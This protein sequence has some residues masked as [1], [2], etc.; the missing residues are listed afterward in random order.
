V[1][2]PESIHSP[3]TW[4]RWFSARARFTTGVPLLVRPSSTG[5]VRRPLDVPDRVTRWL[6]GKPDQAAHLAVRRPWELVDPV[7]REHVEPSVEVVARA[8]L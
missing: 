1:V 7:R 4:R 5:A 6:A 2:V 3:S 8:L